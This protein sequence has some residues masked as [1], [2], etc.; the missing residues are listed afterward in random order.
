MRKIRGSKISMIFQEPS[1]ALNPVVPIGKQ[2]CQPLRVHRGMKKAE[3]MEEAVRLLERVNI[4]NAAERVKQYPF[5]FSGGMQQ[6]AMIAM[7][8]A[9]NPDILI[10]D[11]PTT[12]LDVT[13]QAQVLEELNKEV[14]A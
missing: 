14:Q 7:A 9:C 2:I 5:E 10:A 8:M 1:T 11:E 13:I 6:R 4:P 3:A 12:A